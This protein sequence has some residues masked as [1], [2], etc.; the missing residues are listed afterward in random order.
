M[1]CSCVLQS[2]KGRLGDLVSLMTHMPDN[3]KQTR[4]SAARVL[5]ALCTPSLKVECIEDNI[6]YVRELAKLLDD[7]SPYIRGSTI[8]LLMSIGEQDRAINDESDVVLE[9]LP[10]IESL[11]N[12]P[13][14]YVA[15]RAREFI[16]TYR[17]CGSQDVTLQE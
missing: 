4:A 9:H 7:E 14:R 3:S 10:A 2:V 15:V 13:E 6:T 16:L 12:D 17:S 1:P 5:G 8:E 11:Q